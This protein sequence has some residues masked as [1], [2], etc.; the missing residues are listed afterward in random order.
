MIDRVTKLTVSP[1]VGHPSSSWTISPARL[2][3]RT[4]PP[5][6]YTRSPDSPPGHSAA[7]ARRAPARAPGALA[8]FPLRRPPASPS[9]ADGGALASPARKNRPNTL[10]WVR[11]VFSRALLRSYFLFVYFCLVV[12]STRG[13]ARRGTSVRQSR[14]DIVPPEDLGPEARRDIGHSTASRQAVRESR[15][16]DDGDRQPGR[17]SSSLQCACIDSDD[18]RRWCPSSRPPGRSQTIPLKQ[19]S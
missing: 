8:A 7:S 13:A 14:T 16:G 2:C 1:D 6:P 4:K 12:W 11:I 17:Q 3:G 10:P 9:P 19:V 15:P 18:L 5:D